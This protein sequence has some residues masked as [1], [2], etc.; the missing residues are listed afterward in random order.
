MRRIS[1]RL[2]KAQERF[3][4]AV[5]EYLMS[6]GAKPGGFYDYALDTPAG[7]LHLSVYENWIA[8]RFDDVAAGRAFSEACGRP[9]NPFS[10]KWNFHF[11]DE[12]LDP[13]GVLAYF[14]FFLDRL[15]GWKVE[16]AA[17]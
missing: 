2:A 14:G 10:G 13:A 1:K 11:A 5:T 12:S 15:L 6:K 8:T 9:C 4:S 17:V 7:P 16:A 3:K